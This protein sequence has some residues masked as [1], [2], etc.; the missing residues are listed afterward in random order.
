MYYFHFLFKKKKKKYHPHQA[1]LNYRCLIEH[2]FFSLYPLFLLLAI[3]CFDMI[4]RRILFTKMYKNTKNL[5][6]FSSMHENILYGFFFSVTS[7]PN[8]CSRC[9]PAPVPFV[10][11]V[12]DPLCYDFPG[13]TCY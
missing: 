3:M 5:F 9:P 10:L 4:S 13:Y 11:F 6:C 8:F 12:L 2:S 1:V 7:I